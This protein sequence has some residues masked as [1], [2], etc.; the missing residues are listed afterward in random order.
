MQYLLVDSHQRFIGTFNSTETL[1]VGDTFQNHD[2]QTYAVVGLNWSRQT[3]PKAPAL[4]V[5]PL[6]QLTRNSKANKLEAAVN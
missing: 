3:T 6:A 2:E 5:I 1:A 4:T